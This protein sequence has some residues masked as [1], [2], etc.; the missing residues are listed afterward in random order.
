MTALLGVILPTET[1]RMGVLVRN[2]HP[3]ARETETA[4][5][6]PQVDARKQR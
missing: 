3:K 2:S 6:K 1:V 5:S 4:M